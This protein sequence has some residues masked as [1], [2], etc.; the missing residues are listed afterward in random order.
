[1]IKTILEM[2]LYGIKALEVQKVK[3]YSKK[4]M[5]QFFGYQKWELGMESTV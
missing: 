1:M 3:D 2:K 5:K 4:R